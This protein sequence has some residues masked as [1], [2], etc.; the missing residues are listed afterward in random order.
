MNLRPSGYE[1]DELPTAPLRDRGALWERFI[2]IVYRGGKVN[3]SGRNI[4]RQIARLF[5]VQPV[6]QQVGGDAE[7]DRAFQQREEV[8]AEQP[9]VR[10]GDAVSEH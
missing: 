5:Q 7:A 8:D 4:P 6:L 9:D 3:S 1:P 10:R 2:I